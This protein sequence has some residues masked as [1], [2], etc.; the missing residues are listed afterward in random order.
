M[1][2]HTFVG[3]DLPTGWRVTDQQQR[4]AGDTG[5][6]FSVGFYVEKDGRRAFMKV[7]DLDRLMKRTR[8]STAAMRSWLELF[9]HE[10]KMLAKCKAN[11]V[12]HVVT[13]LDHGKFLFP[14]L[15]PNIEFEYLVF[16]MAERDFRRH[17]NY[18]A[19][20]DLGVVLV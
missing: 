1:V 14:A 19:A 16:E 11:G 5:G 6:N 17:Y 9:E 12:T 8:G 13:V 4:A 15:N 2:W 18:S 10:C 20:L 7:F 3:T